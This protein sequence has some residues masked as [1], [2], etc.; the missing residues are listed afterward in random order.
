MIL[1]GKA[2]TLGE[3][4]DT[5]MI[6]G[7]QYLSIADPIDL[8]RHCF[9]SLEPNWIEKISNGDILVA[10]SNFGCGSSREHAPM[11]LKAAGISCIIAESYGAI[12]FRNA[13]NLGLPAIEFTKARQRFSGGDILAV[14]ICSNEVENVTTGKTYSFAVP[15]V[16]LVIEILQ[17][18]GL[19][20]Y[21]TESAFLVDKRNNSK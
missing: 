16:P 14:N 3:N 21:I 11:A 4:I 7:G 2:W 15:F 5:D 19:L 13:I 10:G 1:R 18:G 17:A 20:A 12:F 9:E 8:A 6:I